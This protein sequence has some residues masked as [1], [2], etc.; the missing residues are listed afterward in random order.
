M[1]GGQAS[2]NQAPIFHVKYDD[3]SAVD[4]LSVGEVNL[5][6]VNPRSPQQPETDL[7]NIREKTE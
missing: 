6:E 2:T 4:Q 1:D 7:I 3:V 5:N